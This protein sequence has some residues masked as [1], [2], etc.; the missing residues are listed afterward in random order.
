M[1]SSSPHDS[2]MSA[3]NCHSAGA[4][5]AGGAMSTSPPP[6]SSAD[7]ETSTRAV[8]LLAPWYATAEA[9]VE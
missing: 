4:D 2:S 6:P 9:L 5:S 8:P 7:A 3:A 1:G